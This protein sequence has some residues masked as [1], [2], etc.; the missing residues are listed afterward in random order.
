MIIQELCSSLELCR[1]IPKSKLQ[2]GEADR[3]QMK[4]EANIIAVL[5]II[6]VGCIITGELHWGF[7]IGILFLGMLQF[8][9][10]VY[11]PRL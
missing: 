2:Q 9:L 8:H 1:E 4:I 11:R 6:A 3:Q 10:A 7:A 5:L